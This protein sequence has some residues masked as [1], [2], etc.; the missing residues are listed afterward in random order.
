MNSKVNN[1]AVE[2]EQFRLQLDWIP[3]SRN[4]LADSLSHLLDMVPDAQQVDEA[5][6]HEFGSYCFEEL[7]PTKP[8]EIVAT[9]VIE[10][11][12][13]A[14]ETVD[15]S[16][17]SRKLTKTNECNDKVTKSTEEKTKMRV[18]GS[19]FSEYLQNSWTLNKVGIFEL[20]YDK[21]FCGVVVVERIYTNVSYCSFVAP[22]NNSLE[23][24]K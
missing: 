5:K 17:K 7:E 9:E 13:E 8:L 16:Q 24:Y 12:V 3:G 23:V 19:K 10:P 18:E 2:L 1:L 22:G 6:D 20:K 14:G 21:C 15:S 4:L 11:Q